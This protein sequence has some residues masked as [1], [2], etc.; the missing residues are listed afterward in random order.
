MTWRATVLPGS[1]RGV[2]FEVE[3]HE[4]SGGRRGPLHEYALRDN[5]WFEDMGRKARSFTVDAF[6]VGENYH[7]TRQAMLDA[8]EQPGPGVLVHPYLGTRTVVCTDFRLSERIGEGR[9]CRFSLTFVEAGQQLFPSGF[10]DFPYQVGNLAGLA[11]LAAVG[12]FVANYQAAGLPG[13]VFDSVAGVAGRFIDSLTGFT[14]AESVIRFAGAYLDDLQGLMRS[15]QDFGTRTAGLVETLRDSAMASPRDT[16]GA[17]LVQPQLAQLSA[18]SAADEVGRV[19]QITPTRVAEAGNMSAFAALVRNTAL[20]AEAR[21]VPALTFDS[22][23]AATSYSRGFVN[24]VD[25]VLLGG[26]S[27]QAELPFTQMAALITNDLSTR[28]GALPR[29]QRITLQDTRPSLVLANDLY[30]DATRSTDITA[31]NAVR[32]P[33]FMPT[34]RPL[35]VL[36]A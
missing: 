7:L 28:A 10:T 25:D 12:D 9:M 22:Y 26:A 18:F 24:R 30:G 14:G 15:P 11:S 34:G 13:Y 1:W 17:S 23:D 21:T 33:S 36:N 31:R 29:L 20:A 6:V 8:C 4:H 2:P 5:P 19:N 32:N 35:E 16:A 3:S 27:E